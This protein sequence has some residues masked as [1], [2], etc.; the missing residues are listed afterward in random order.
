MMKGDMNTLLTE[1]PAIPT[2]MA[3][4]KKLDVVSIDKILPSELVITAK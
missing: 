3:N 4:H 1:N 2:P